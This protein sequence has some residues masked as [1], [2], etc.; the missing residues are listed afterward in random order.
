MLIC[1][2]WRSGCWRIS[3][4]CNSFP[5]LC[6]PFSL[7]MGIWVRLCSFV[8]YSNAFSSYVPLLF[9]GCRARCSGILTTFIFL[10]V[11]VFLLCNSIELYAISLFRIHLDGLYVMKVPF[12]D[13]ILSASMLDVA[14]YSC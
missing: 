12:C 2:C 5:S 3:W 4:K 9:H 6:Y 11:S 8:L 1:Y 10:N 14:Q 7:L 13:I